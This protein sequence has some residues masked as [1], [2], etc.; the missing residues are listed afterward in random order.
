MLDDSANAKTEATPR[1]EA[2]TSDSGAG[3]RS[4]IRIRLAEPGDEASAGNMFRRY[5]ARTAFS[6]LPYSEDRFALAWRRGIERVVH[7]VVLVAERDGDIVGVAHASCGAY[8]LSE[9][10]ITT[11]HLIVIDHDRLSGFGRVKTFHRLLEALRRWSKARGARRVVIN[12]TSGLNI[13]VTDRL[14]RSAGGRMIGGGYL[15]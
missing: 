2:S 15:L 10:L 1:A 8:I 11:V 7:R 6:D 9:D 13:G 12:N 14:V 4:R 3:N 5:H